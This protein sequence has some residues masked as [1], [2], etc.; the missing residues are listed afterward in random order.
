VGF[1]RVTFILFY[2]LMC[3]LKL[4]RCQNGHFWIKTWVFVPAVTMFVSMCIS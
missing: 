4:A 2:S 1:K 3:T